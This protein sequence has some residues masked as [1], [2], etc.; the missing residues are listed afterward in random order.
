MRLR[1][2]YPYPHVDEVVMAVQE[3]ISAEKVAAEVGR[4]IEVIVDAVDPEAGTATGRSAGDAPEID[5]VVQLLGEVRSA[6]ATSSPRSPRRCWNR[7]PTI[8][9]P[10]SRT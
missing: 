5:G 6:R 7:T 8:R 10:R 4:T 2:V 1:Y 3:R 9:P